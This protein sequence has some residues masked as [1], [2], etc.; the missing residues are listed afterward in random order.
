MLILAT[1]PSLCAGF[2]SYLFTPQ[3]VTLKCGTSPPFLHPFWA[4]QGDDAMRIALCLMGSGHSLHGFPPPCSHHQPRNHETLLCTRWLSPT[5]SP[6]SGTSVLGLWGSSSWPRS[7][8]PAPSHQWTGGLLCSQSL[9]I[10]TS[11]LR[12]WRCSCVVCSHPHRGSEDLLFSSLP[13]SPPPCVPSVHRQTR[14]H[15][16]SPFT[17]VVQLSHCTECVGL[18]LF[19][20]FTF[21]PRYF[22][23]LA[24]GCW[25]S[26]SCSPPLSTDAITVTV[27]RAT[28]LYTETSGEL[29]QHV[30]G[31][32]LF[33]CS[34][35][36]L[37]SV[38]SLYWSS[39]NAS[40]PQVTSPVQLTLHSGQ[41]L[42][43]CLINILG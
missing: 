30:E 6:C 26:L 27:Y 24:G 31:A 10:S 22:M 21:L 38:T 39:R 29:H 5:Y 35:R 33:L 23:V 41:G 42:L 40:P 9:S 14:D 36:I 37:C 3:P 18:F 25:S 1:F 8:S 28:V 34:M 7:H 16:L 15:S 4:L 17:L 2:S 13:F 12:V 43:Y 20:M 11:V 19:A 32:G